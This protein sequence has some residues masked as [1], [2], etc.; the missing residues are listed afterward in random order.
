MSKF[1]KGDRV[2]IHLSNLIGTV[3]ATAPQYVTIPTGYCLATDDGLMGWYREEQ[4][5]KLEP[6][7]KL[8]KLELTLDE[9]S[10]LDAIAYE[11]FLQ[12][13]P[14]P[15]KHKDLIERIATLNVEECRKRDD[16]R[17]GEKSQ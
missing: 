5:S 11:Y 14:I 6:A 2:K 16:A 9:L 7:N 17:F 3:V 10:R 8:I 12:N 13:A 1:Q 15:S 4:L